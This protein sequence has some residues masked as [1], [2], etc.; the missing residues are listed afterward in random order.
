[1]CTKSQ[2]VLYASYMLQREDAAR[3]KSKRKIL[4][5]DLRSFTVVTWKRFKEIDDRFFPNTVRSDEEELCMRG[6]QL[7]VASEICVGDRVKTTGMYWCAYGGLSPSIQKERPN[8]LC[9]YFRTN[10]KLS[11]RAITTVYGCGVT[12]WRDGY[13]QRF[14]EAFSRL[15]GPLTALTKRNSKF[16]YIDKCEGSFQE[17]K[18]RLIST[19]VL[20][21]PESRK[22]FVVFCDAF[23]FGL[24]CVPMQEGQ[25]VGYVS[26]Q[27]KDHEKKYPTDDVELVVVVFALKI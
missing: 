20:V 10:V 7:K 15:S 13:Y 26:R 6:K 21:L 8:P 11:H 2:K 17:L 27:L 18:K 22:S 12:K 14:V 24:G 3:W 19:P 16:V 1:M 5:M 25:V 4:E 23:K 9:C